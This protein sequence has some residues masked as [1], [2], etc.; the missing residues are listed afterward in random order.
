MFSLTS[1]SYTIPLPLWPHEESTEFYFKV[2]RISPCIWRIEATPIEDSRDPKN[3]KTL[4]RSN[5]YMTIRSPNPCYIPTLDTMICEP[6]LVCV[7]RRPQI[8]PILKNIVCIVCISLPL[9][10][11][12]SPKPQPYQME[13]EAGLV[14]SGPMTQLEAEIWIQNM[15]NHFGSNL[16]SRKYEVEHALQY[17]TQ[18]AAIW[19]KM[20]HAIQGFSGAETWDEFK[21]T[22]LRSR[23]IQKCYD[24]PDEETLCMQD[25]WRNRTHPGRTEG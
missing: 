25:L 23:L 5:I 22:L 19:W 2:K 20:H 24:K 1:N 17:F 13:Y 15:E 10:P 4:K 14:V 8:K 7:F 3:S 6:S 18:S 16:I 12:S 11:V 21:N 9:L